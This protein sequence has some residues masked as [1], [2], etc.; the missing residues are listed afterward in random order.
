MMFCGEDIPSVIYRMIAEVRNKIGEQL[1]ITIA[2]LGMIL[3]GEREGIIA[4]SHLLDDVIGGAPGFDLE[5][6][7]EFIEGLMMRAV[8]FIKAMR[9]RALRPQRLDVVI[10]HFRGVV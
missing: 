6:V 3:D 9:G 8:N 10:L 5:A 2:P 7:P 4:E 1:L